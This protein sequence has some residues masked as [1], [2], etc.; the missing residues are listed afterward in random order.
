MSQQKLPQRQKRHWVR[1]IFL[2]IIGLGALIVVI[3]LAM[4]GGGVSQTPTLA[5]DTPTQPATHVATPK[6]LGS[7]FDVQDSRG[8]TYG[9]ALTKLID[10]ARTTDQITPGKAKRFV[11]AV[12]IIKAISSSGPQQEDAESDAA[13]V[14]SNG[15]TYLS[16][17]I[18]IVGYTD[19]SLGEIHAAQG[20]IAT[21]AIAFQVPTE[22]KVSKIQWS[23]FSSSGVQSIVQW[24]VPAH[25]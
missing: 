7:Y 14:G 21:G 15:K 13:L 24:N 20:D 1:N 11:G 9:V 22:V 18:P 10:P 17:I 5:T 3:L 4:S 2:G 8:D 6:S 19:F 25:H 16:D 23:T 12:F